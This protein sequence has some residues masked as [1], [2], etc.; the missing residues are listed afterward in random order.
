[1]GGKKSLVPRD[2]A[3]VA[4][5]P[6]GSFLERRGGR[7]RE[8]GR[9]VVRIPMRNFPGKL[10]ERRKGSSSVEMHLKDFF[11]PLLSWEMW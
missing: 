6:P 11:L 2:C 7:E 10:Q 9:D 3:A 8:G 1:M 5:I 4:S